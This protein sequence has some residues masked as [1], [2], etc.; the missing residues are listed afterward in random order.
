MKVVD[1]LGENWLMAT[2]IHKLETR[3]WRK[4][5]RDKIKV[6]LFTSASRGEGK[7]TTVACL[8]TSLGLYPGRRVLAVDLDFR[9]PQLN[10]H[11][12]LAVR[13][14]VGDVLRGKCAVEQAVISTGL[15]SL[16]VVLPSPEGED[17]ALLLKTTELWEMFVQ[18]RKSYDL[19][20]MDVP[21]LIPV[22]DA[23][24]LMPLADGVVLVAMAGKTTKHELSKARELCLGMDANILGL[25]VGNLQEALPEYG[26]GYGYGYGSY[27]E[28]GKKASQADGDRVKR[29]AS[30]RS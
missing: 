2:E 18:F 20:L 28:N 19:V 24:V 17:P 11:F 10:S 4:S 6:I 22:A 14:G 12:D 13:H 26:Y 21:A 15:P 9:E 30:E 16:D 23:S 27:Q 3:L 5:Q 29:E 7:S 25:V 1:Q 8:A